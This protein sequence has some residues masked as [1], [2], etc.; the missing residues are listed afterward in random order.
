MLKTILLASAMIVTVPAV[1]QD[2]PQQTAPAS[3]TATAQDNTATSPQQTP[4]TQGAPISGAPVTE[5]ATA[6]AADPAATP[7][8]P[9]TTTAPAE[10]AATAPATDAAT[11]ATGSTQIAQVV[12]TEFPTYDKNA[13]KALD[14]LEFGQW[15]VALKSASDPS[16]KPTDPATKKWVEGAFASADKDKSKSVTQAELTTYL[17]QGAG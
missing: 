4:T 11:P 6:P 1:A 15:M 17:S 3:T 5:Q 12:S 13:D 16:T 14:K 10:T 8:D 2:M 7:A 9:A